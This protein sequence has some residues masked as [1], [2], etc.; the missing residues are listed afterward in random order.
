MLGTVF[1]LGL[2]GIGAPLDR[3]WSTA[4]LPLQVAGVMLVLIVV[5]GIR[6]HRSLDAANPL[7]WLLAAGF[8]TLLA[9]GSAFYFRMN[10]AEAELRDSSLNSSIF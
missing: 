2:A 6:E 3:R 8:L 1:C 10:R 5:A 7:T 9:G 4:R